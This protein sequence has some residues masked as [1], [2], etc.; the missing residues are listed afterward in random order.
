MREHEGAQREQMDEAGRSGGAKRRGLSQQTVTCCPG[1]GEVIVVVV[2]F[3]PPGG[4]KH[5]GLSRYQP[6]SLLLCPCPMIALTET[7][8]SLLSSMLAYFSCTRVAVAGIA[9]AFWRRFYKC[10]TSYGQQPKQ[11]PWCYGVRWWA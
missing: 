11:A 2:E 10:S 6:I 8:I 4:S 7:S 5:I 1:F 9:G 3:I